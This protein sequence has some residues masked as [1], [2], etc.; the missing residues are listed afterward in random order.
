VNVVQNEA[1]EYSGSESPPYV[2]PSVTRRSVTLQTPS[3]LSVCSLEVLHN[4]SVP[5]PRT[6][7]ARFCGAGVSVSS[8][9]YTPWAIKNVPLYF[10][11]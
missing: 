6:S 7:G 9:V 1:S 4:E 5:F 8:Y 10:G 2:R 11:L 3:F